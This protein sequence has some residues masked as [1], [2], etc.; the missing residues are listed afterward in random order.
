MLDIKLPDMNGFIKDCELFGKNLELET[1]KIGKKVFGED[2]DLGGKDKEDQN[3]DK[4][5][6]GGLEPL[7]AGV[8]SVFELRVTSRWLGMEVLRLVIYLVS[9]A[10]TPFLNILHFIVWILL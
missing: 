5:L 6:L 8:K 9:T 7:V 2:F 1:W 3:K 4:G 10:T